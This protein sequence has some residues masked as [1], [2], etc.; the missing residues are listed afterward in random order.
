[1]FF[2]SIEPT[3]PKSA[4]AYVFLKDGRQIFSHQLKKKK[5]K[6]SRRETTSKCSLRLQLVK[7][8]SSLLKE[9]FK[10]LN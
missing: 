10:T 1:M 5:K 2:Q 6:K 4:N 3:A 8:L 9:I 7:A